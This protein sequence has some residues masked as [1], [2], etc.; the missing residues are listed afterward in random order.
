MD[1]SDV[2]FK[3]SQHQYQLVFVML[4][5][6]ILDGL[7]TIQDERQFYNS[8]NSLS[9]M[10][11]HNKKQSEMPSSSHVNNSMQVIVTVPQMH[12]SLLRGTGHTDDGLE[13][14]IAQLDVKTLYVSHVRK[15]DVETVVTLD[16]MIAYDRRRD[17]KNC[18]NTIFDSR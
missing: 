13:D 5:D 14:P 11:K 4:H 2:S 10:R 18:F 7:T 16:S 12:V 1:I 3:M 17:S 8:I 6:N 15:M 9:K